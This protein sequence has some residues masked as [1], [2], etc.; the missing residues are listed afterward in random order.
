MDQAAIATARPPAEGPDSSPGTSPEWR[1]E[2]SPLP[3]PEA[4]A[5]M[6]ARVD[7][8]RAGVGVDTVVASIEDAFALG[9][10][11][12]PSYR[13]D[14]RVLRGVQEVDALRAR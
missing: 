7:A 11:G 10:T 8:I 6:E 14:G 2:A 3:Y 1:W 9:I 13:I 12:T 4:V 5:A